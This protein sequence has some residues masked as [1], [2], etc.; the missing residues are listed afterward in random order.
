MVTTTIGSEATGLEHGSQRASVRRRTVR[1]I[2]VYWPVDTATL[3]ACAEGDLDMLR[4]DE[5]FAS[6]VRVL[7]ATPELGDFGVYGDVFEVAFGAEGFTVRPGARPS[8]G[9]VGG[10]FLSST[11]AVTTYVDAGVDDDEL[12]RVLARLADA[13]PWE[14][15]VIELSAPLDLVTRA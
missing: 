11:L 8:L 6:L 12:A 10:R 9:S 14:V 2:K 15:P 1:T 3:V 4:S 13:H 7:E 5:S